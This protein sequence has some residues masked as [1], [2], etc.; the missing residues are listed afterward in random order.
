MVSVLSKIHSC[1]FLDPFFSLFG[2]NGMLWI[3]DPLLEGAKAIRAFYEVLFIS[4]FVA[5]VPIPGALWT[6]HVP[7]FGRQFLVDFPS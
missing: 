2:V 5:F 4:S 1:K 3:S 7:F 6:A